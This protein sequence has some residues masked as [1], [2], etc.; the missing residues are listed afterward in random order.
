MSLINQMLRD[1]QQRQEN[2][3]SGAPARQ[4]P[5]RS[6]R[7][8]ETPAKAVPPLLWV[9]AGGIAALALL[10]GFSDR[11]QQI[12]A[13]D[14][15]PA[16]P[17]AAVPAAVAAGSAPPAISP[18]VSAAPAKPA[19]AVTPP[20]P[21]S[22]VGPLTM[23]V[24]PRPVSVAAP[25]GSELPV[26]SAGPQTAAASAS[27]PRRVHPDLL[28]GAVNAA[29]LALQ[30][31]VRAAGA[32]PPP[33]ST[34][35]GRA[36]EA[37]RDGREAYA[38]NRT[39]LTLE[40]LRR[41]LEFYPGHLPAREL[42]ADQLELDG[43]VDEAHDLLRQGLAMAPDYTPFRKRTARLL[44]DRGDAAGAVQVLTGNGLPRV[45]A[46]PELHRLLARTYLGLGENFLAAQTYR[47]LLVH[48]PGVGSC[49]LGLGDALAADGQPDEA[50]RA[51]RRALAVGGLSGEDAARAGVGAARP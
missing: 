20:R 29:N 16:A 46:D 25:R 45:E 17:P 18:T 21:A 3:S 1:L 24:A 33:A 11:F 2:P 4:E 41:A 51:Y 43:R 15:S 32:A 7:L 30:Q 23:P 37:Y 22:P 26:A 38:A 10:W 44:L 6:R 8:P 14:P 42:L 34:P 13:P 35:Y 48:E 49:W 47:N 12:G 40:A 28:P 19:A 27:D 9:G 50:R 39:D 31:A 36:E 5:A